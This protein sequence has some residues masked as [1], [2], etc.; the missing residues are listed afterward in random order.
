MSQKLIILDR[1]GVINYDSLDYIKSPE[2][3]QPLPGSIEAI[4]N[5]SKHGYNIVVATN[6]SGL[7]RKLFTEV[8]LANM[9]QLMSDLVEEAGGSISAVFFCPH[10]PDDNCSCRKPNT[11]LLEQVER[12]FSCSV[13]G[14]WFVGDTEK[15]IDTA[16]AKSCKPILVLTG[17]GLQTQ[18]NLSAE[19]QSSVLIFDDLSAAS[20]FILK[21]DNY[22]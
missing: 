5:L 12:E 15:D 14:C 4:A 6:Q 7:A 20:N 9:H 2:E 8:T 19:K 1:D 16:I 21:E 11:G 3:W 22:V 17:K 10:H 13:S 18:T